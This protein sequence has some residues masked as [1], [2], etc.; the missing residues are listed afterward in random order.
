M[1]KGKVLLAPFPLELNENLEAVGSVY[2]YALK[3]AGVTPAYSVSVD[4]PG[5]LICPTE[6]PHA[7]LYVITSESSQRQASF[8]D[9]R[10]NKEFSEQL[11]PGRASLLLVAEDG[12]I[13]ASYNW[14]PR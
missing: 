12:A 14:H 7:T 8:R 13:L 1:G 3:M 4:D 2:R 11:D 9:R 6:F 5:I 10:S